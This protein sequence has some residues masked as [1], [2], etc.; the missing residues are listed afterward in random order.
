MICYWWIS[1]RFVC[2]CVSRFVAFEL[3]SSCVSRFSSQV[4]SLSYRNMA[5]LD[6]KG[7]IV[8]LKL[9]NPQETQI[10]EGEDESV[11][12]RQHLI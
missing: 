6:S 2:F 8:S 7:E 5:N 12:S 11:R 3:K 4:F 1:I 10:W 9:P